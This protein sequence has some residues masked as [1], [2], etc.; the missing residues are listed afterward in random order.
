MADTIPTRSRM[1]NSRDEDYVRTWFVN[2]ELLARIHCWKHADLVRAIEE[3]RAPAPSYI[4]ADGTRMVP[5]DY[6]ALFATPEELETLKDR[7]ERRL[8]RAVDTGSLS[9][10]ERDESWAGYISGGFGA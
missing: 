9:D 10:E 7:F 5:P 2:L 1:I 4:L 8:H 3:L 6:F